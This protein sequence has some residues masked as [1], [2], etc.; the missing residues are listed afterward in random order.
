[1]PGLPTLLTSKSVQIGIISV[2]AVGLAIGGFEAG[3]KSIDAVA[4]AKTDA[5]EAVAQRSADSVSQKTTLLERDHSKITVREIATVP[6]SELYD[7]LKSAPREQLLAWAADLEQMPRGPRQRAAVA[8]YYKSLIQVDHHAAIDAVLHA[9]NLNLRDVAIVSLMKAAPESIWGDLAEMI[10]QLPHPRR[11][12]SFSPVDPL[13]NWSR[14]DPVVVSRFIE[15]H[16]DSSLYALLYNW[17]AIDPAAAR[18][19]LERDTSRHTEE[20]FRAFLTGWVE[21]DR[22]AAMEYA[23]NNS[24]RANFEGAVNELAYHLFRVS[25]DDAS[26]LMSLLPPEQAKAAMKVVAHNTTS[27]ILHAPEDYQR[28]PD[29]VARWMA[30]QPVELWKDDIGDVLWGWVRDDAD[31][32]TGWLDQLQPNVR[33]AAIADFCRRGPESAEDPRRFD[34]KAIA[35]GLTITDRTLRDEA[36]GEFAR[37]LG[38][39]RDEAIEAI[40]QL[41]ISNEQKTYLR[42][43]MPEAVHE[44]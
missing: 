12:H 11:L 35:L 1:M 21:I 19:W 15:K 8:A 24:T 30:T 7:I 31:A 23:V 42:K 39:T 9:E 26:R 41:G 20:A 43:V 10:E 36:L 33:D 16:P 32:A 29:V 18:E 22:A 5:P 28:P 4:V 37:R 13:S 25:P 44:R 40:E 17:G 38:S 3:R 2:V 14:V 34:E 6:F 27:I